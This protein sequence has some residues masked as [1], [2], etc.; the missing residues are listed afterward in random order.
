LTV[1]SRRFISISDGSLRGS[2]GNSVR[3]HCAT[4]ELP[5]QL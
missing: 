3:A 2:K 4:P 1:I 5:P